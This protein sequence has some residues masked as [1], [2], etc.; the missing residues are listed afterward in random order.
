MR[1]KVWEMTIEERHKF[2]D[3]LTFDML[4]CLDKDEAEL[5]D[6]D[7]VREIILDEDFSD[8]EDSITYKEYYG[9]ELSEEEENYLE[10]GSKLDDDLGLPL[11][12][13]EVIATI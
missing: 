12:S 6:Q 2:E 4:D 8:I 11:M 10:W 1:K 3:Q 13:R 7:I 5:L 9:V